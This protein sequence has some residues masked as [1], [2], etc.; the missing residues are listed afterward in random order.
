VGGWGGVSGR[1]GWGKWEG[2]V[3]DGVG[4]GVGEG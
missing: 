3:G 4:G 1:M 2:G